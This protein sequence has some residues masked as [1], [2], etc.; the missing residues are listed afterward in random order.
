[1]VSIDNVYRTVLNILNKE[2]RGYITPTEFNTLAKQA[3]TEI[4]E[5][6]F[7]SQHQVSLEP[8]VDLEYSKQS[9][10]EEKIAVFEKSAS[11]VGTPSTDGSGKTIRPYPDDFYR[12]S[13]VIINGRIADPVSNKEA[14][15]INLSPLTKP[16][17]TQPIFTRTLGGIEILPQNDT[18]QVEMIYLKIPD[19]PEW[20]GTTFNGQLIEGASTNFELHPSEEPELV[21]KILAY[22]GVI[23]R[24]QEV[25]Q[26]AAAK[27]AQITQS[28][29]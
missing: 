1:M 9:N 25:I 3:Q 29:Q 24:S 11:S 8:D 7:S 23:V 12:L 5:S 22:S 13:T 18:L 27:E 28:E 10:I 6:Y 15:Y 4:F 17:S 16:T 20:V 19:T 2:N 14:T 26:A 21:V